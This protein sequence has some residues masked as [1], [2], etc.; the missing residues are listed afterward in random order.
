M[1]N[2]NF[3]TILNKFLGNLQMVER[4][5]LHVR[6]VAGNHFSNIRFDAKLGA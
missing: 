5:G 2:R 6:R 4:D 1:G 3:E